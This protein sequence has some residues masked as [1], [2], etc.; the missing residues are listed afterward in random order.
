MIASSRVTVSCGT[1]RNRKSPGR[2]ADG[3]RAT[4]H[5]AT[6]AS[7]PRAMLRFRV[8][9]RCQ[10]IQKNWFMFFAWMTV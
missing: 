4:P 6:E 1:R 9:R 7:T 5:A 3:T 8:T 2:S 10:E